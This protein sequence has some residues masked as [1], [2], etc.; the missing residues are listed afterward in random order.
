[1]ARAALTLALRRVARAALTLALRRVAWASGHDHAELIRLVLLGLDGI[2]VLVRLRLLR[3]DDVSILVR[4]RL[5][6]L[7]DVSILVRL[8]LLRLDGI[9]VLIR[10]QHLAGLLLRGRRGGPVDRSAAGVRVVDELSLLGQ[11]RV[12]DDLGAD[13]L[14]LVRGGVV[15]VVEEELV[16]LHHVALQGGGN[17][18]GSLLAHVGVASGEGEAA[19]LT[20]VVLADVLGHAHQVHGIDVGGHLGRHRHDDVVEDGE[21]RLLG[22]LKGRLN[23]LSL[24]LRPGEVCVHQ[25]QT[26]VGHGLHSVQMVHARAL[27]LGGGNSR[28]LL[29]LSDEGVDVGELCLAD[30]H[31]DSPQDID[32]VRHRLPVEGHIILDVQIQ[33]FIEGLHRLAGPAHKISLVQLI[34]A[35]LV[36]DVQVGVPEYGHDPD[37]PGVAVD[38][39]HHVDIRVGSLARV[40]SPAV[41]AE[42]GHRPVAL[43]LLQGL[44]RQLLVLHALDAE[45]LI[46]LEQGPPAGHKGVGENKHQGKALGYDELDDP[47]AAFGLRAVLP[48][49]GSGASSPRLAALARAAACAAGPASS[50]GPAAAAGIRLQPVVLRHG[51]RRLPPA[52]ALRHAASRRAGCRPAVLCHAGCCR[53]VLCRVGCRSAASLPL[54]AAGKLIP[55]TDALL[56]PALSDAGSPA[57]C[58]RRG[59]SHRSALRV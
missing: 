40:A 4:L 42:D 24:A 21:I 55:E 9:S 49:G 5:L 38:V 58:V 14:H 43:H 39:E 10:L 41:H 19:G 51:G 48:V 15:L 12:G 46:P 20:D 22:L 8:R 59:R 45:G 54:C 13:L 53:A 47:P 52:A 6:R 33:V 30:L 16:Q 27:Q 18:A 3:L 2:S 36:V 50:A 1:M 44:V 17:H 57:P 35:S 7:D 29:G 25:A 26:A 23:H 32:G 37:L 56:V 34:V 11:A 31:V 28:R